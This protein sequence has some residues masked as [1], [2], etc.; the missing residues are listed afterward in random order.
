STGCIFSFRNNSTVGCLPGIQLTVI[1][2]IAINYRFFGS[3][4]DYGF[5]EIFLC[6]GSRQIGVQHGS[7]S[8]TA[9]GLTRNGSCDGVQRSGN[10]SSSS[11]DRRQ[12]GTAGGDVGSV[13]LSTALGSV[14]VG[15]SDLVVDDG[16]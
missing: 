9:N 7:H 12:N 3:W 10:R 16:F 2:N 13:E 14:V 4:V 5:G 1:V 15:N 6:L 11:V 8:S